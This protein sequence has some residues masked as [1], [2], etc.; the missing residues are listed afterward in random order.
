MF[1]AQCSIFN[2]VIAVDHNAPLRGER[3]FLLHPWATNNAPL[4]GWGSKSVVGS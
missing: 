1:N 3:G 2:G 4:A